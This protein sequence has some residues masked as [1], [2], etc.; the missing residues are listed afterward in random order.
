MTLPRN[1]FHFVLMDGAF[2]YFMARFVEYNART[3]ARSVL[4]PSMKLLIALIE[5]KRVVHVAIDRR[6]F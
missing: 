4:F 1:I 3:H 5:W 2:N 6:T